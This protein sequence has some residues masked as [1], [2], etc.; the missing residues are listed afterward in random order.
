VLTVQMQSVPPEVSCPSQF[1]SKTDLQVSDPGVTSPTQPVEAVP[2][3]L[4]Y[5]LP[6]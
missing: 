1:S 4:Q 2:V 5:D 3:A 6:A